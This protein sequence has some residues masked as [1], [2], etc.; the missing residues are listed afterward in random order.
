MTDTAPPKGY[1]CSKCGAENEF[2]SYVYAHWREIL[3]HTC[4]CGQKHEICH[5]I[6]SPVVEST[7]KKRKAAK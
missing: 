2:S 6:A 7:S 1:K 4:E 5:G 3:T